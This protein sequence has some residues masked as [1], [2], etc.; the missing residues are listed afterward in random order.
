MSAKVPTFLSREPTDAQLQSVA[1]AQGLCVSADKWQR[2][3]LAVLNPE[4]DG[5]NNPHLVLAAVSRSDVVS[6]LRKNY[7]HHRELSPAEVLTRM[8]PTF[9][10]PHRGTRRIA[11]VDIDSVNC[12]DDDDPI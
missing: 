1:R 2:Y 8:F 7:D 4:R 10:T 5:T 9:S 3:Y 12:E 11:D 6:Y